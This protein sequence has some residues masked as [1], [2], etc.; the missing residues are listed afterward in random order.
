MRVAVLVDKRVKGRAHVALVR[1]AVAETMRREQVPE[2]YEVS[3]VLAD[4][5]FVRQLNREYMGVDGTTDVLSF[6]LEDGG[7]PIHDRA[8]PG[9]PASTAARRALG[10]IV[11][12]VPTVIRQAVDHQVT[13]ESEMALMVVHSSLHLLGYDHDTP[14]ARDR[15]WRRQDEIAA[16]VL[17]QFSR[18]TIK[19]A[20]GDHPG[21]QSCGGCGK[22][23]RSSGGKRSGSNQSQRESCSGRPAAYG[24]EQ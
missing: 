7:D 5:T 12:S 4:D 15:M 6:P 11:I 19:K 1:R 22:N 14:A 18:A 13:V 16:A 2:P 23:S 24:L 3:V 20:A 8:H 21:V 9:Q 17:N 10:D